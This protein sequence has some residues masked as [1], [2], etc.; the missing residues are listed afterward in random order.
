[1]ISWK[2][3]YLGHWQWTQ[4]IPNPGRRGHPS[5]WWSCTPESLGNYHTTFWP[6]R[7]DPQAQRCSWVGADNSRPPGY[8]QAV[9]ATITRIHSWDGV[10][11]SRPLVCAQVATAAATRIQTS[12]VWTSSAWGW[13]A[14][15][16]DSQRGPAGIDLPGFHLDGDNQEWIH[17]QI[18]VLVWITGSRISM[19]ELAWYPG[20]AWGWPRNH[21]TVNQAW[22]PLRTDTLCLDSPDGRLR[23]QNCDLSE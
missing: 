23:I 7:G 18:Q 3:H 12:S 5:V 8:V 1:M 4:D 11:C 13:R 19:S 21:Q 14:Q 17:R 6:S 9:T 15:S 16:Q 20:P 10:D 22:D 2:P